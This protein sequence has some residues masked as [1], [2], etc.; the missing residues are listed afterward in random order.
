[1]KQNNVNIENNVANEVRRRRKHSHNGRP[2]I[3]TEDD[4]NKASSYTDDRKVLPGKQSH[5]LIK[6]LLP[7]SCKRAGTA[8]GRHLF[9]DL[10]EIL[11]NLLPVLIDPYLSSRVVLEGCYGDGENTNQTADADGGLDTKDTNT[12]RI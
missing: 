2:R 4:A 1:M 11:G 3:E 7:L 6:K 5:V 9:V 10:N 8:H 12:F